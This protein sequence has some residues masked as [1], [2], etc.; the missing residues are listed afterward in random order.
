M[1]SLTSDGIEDL[2]PQQNMYHFPRSIIPDGKIPLRST[3]LV[4]MTKPL[5]MSA[6]R[7]HETHLT[8]GE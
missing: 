8:C 7:L 4:E 6:E 2:E 5:R 1:G 3:A